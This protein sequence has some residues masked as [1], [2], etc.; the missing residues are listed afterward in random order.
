MILALAEFRVRLPAPNLMMP[1]E[2]SPVSEPAPANVP[3]K[4]EEVSLRPIWKLCAEVLELR[5][6][7]EPDNEPMT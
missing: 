1:I 2:P 7:P 6:R 5:I 3:L 4:M